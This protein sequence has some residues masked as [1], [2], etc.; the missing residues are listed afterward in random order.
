[1]KEFMNKEV[2]EA[3][4]SGI[5]SFNQIAS[6][7]K[8]SLLLTLGEPDFDTPQEICD[9][10]KKAL[11]DKYTHYAPTIGY[12][13]LIAKISEYELK[14]NNVSYNS[15]EI[16]VT[17]GSTEAITASLFSILNRDDEVIIPTPAFGLYE[18]SLK[19]AG[20][21]YV[22]LDTS[23]N[24]FQI[25]KQMLDN[26]ITEKTKCIVITSPNNPTGTIYTEETLKNIHDAIK[27][28]PIFIICDDCY[29]SL[30]YT[31]RVP[32]FSTYQDIRKQIIVTKSF[33]KSYAMTGWRVGYLLADK[34]IASEIV[35]YHQF[36]VTTVNSF[37]QKACIKALDYNPVMMVNS[38]KERRDYVYNRLLSMGLEVVKPEGAFYIF[39]KI[40]KY[41]MSSYDFCLKFLNEYH[42]CLIPGIYFDCEGYVRISYC[43]N[44]DVLVEAL[45]RLEKYLIDLEKNL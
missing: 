24:N 19:L 41:N 45:N 31:T 37:I 12:N 7:I 1:M 6:G 14:T 10:A 4:L 27:G 38:Y 36:M 15:D 30:V 21:K 28:K 5:R 44:K 22:K 34:E 11:D 23:V 16:I 25:S 39:P 8:D 29:E 2:L 20:A 43:V 33:S 9:E 3:Q 42:V 17:N 32:S 18:S 26:V 40:A 35:K 13:D